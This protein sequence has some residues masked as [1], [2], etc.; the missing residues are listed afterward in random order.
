MQRYWEYNYCCSYCLMLSNDP[1]QKLVISSGTLRCW[2]NQQTCFCSTK[3]YHR[4]PGGPTCVPFCV[5]IM[6]KI[7][8]IVIFFIVHRSTLKGDFCVLR[9]KRLDGIWEH[10]LIH[11]KPAD[12]YSFV[13]NAMMNVCNCHNSERWQKEVCNVILVA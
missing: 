5:K 10:L 6:Q 3:T 2:N 9:T 4:N 11:D 13:C 8:L 12:V 7:D 1:F